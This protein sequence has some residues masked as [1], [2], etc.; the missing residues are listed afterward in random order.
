[1]K[2][3]KTHE[4]LR[5]STNQSRS[6]VLFSK[7]DCIHCTI[8]KNYIESI[9]KEYPLI[10]FYFTKNRISF[11]GEKFDTFPVLVFYEKYAEQGRLVGSNHI[12]HLR[13]ILNLWFKKD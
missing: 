10:G 8:V 11:D 13:E 2:E 5:E 12:T 4:E 7:E 9:E 3:I 6:V 1:M